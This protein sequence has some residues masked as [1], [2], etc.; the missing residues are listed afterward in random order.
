[1]SEDQTL[2]ALS[3]ALGCS[4]ARAAELLEAC[5]GD[6]DRAAAL[7]FA[8]GGAPAPASPVSSPAPASLAAPAAL[9]VTES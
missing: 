8:H 1:M 7:F 3:E 4:A 9:P 2:S 5:T 6:A